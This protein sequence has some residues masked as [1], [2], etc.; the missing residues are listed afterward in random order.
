[1]SKVIAM[2]PVVLDHPMEGWRL[3]EFIAGAGATLPQRIWIDM[4][5]DE[6]LDYITSPQELVEALHVVRETLQAAGHTEIATHVVGGADH[7]ERSWAQRFERAYRW[8]FDGVE[9]DWD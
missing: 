8:A 5:D 3:R 9:P 7:S 6:D 4:G 1:M 2:S